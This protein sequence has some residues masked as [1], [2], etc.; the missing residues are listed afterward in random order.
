[1]KLQSSQ[2]SRYR[3]KSL[4]QVWRRIELQGS[5]T[6]FCPNRRFEKFRRR[7]KLQGFQTEYHN[8]RQRRLEGGRNY[9]VLKLV[10]LPI[11]S[12]WRRKSYMVLKPDFFDVPMNFQLGRVIA[13]FSNKHSAWLRWPYGLEGNRIAG[14]SNLLRRRKR[15]PRD[16]KGNRIA[17]CSN[18]A[19]I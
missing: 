12:F 11:H 9:M 14:F 19:A 15:R 1:M 7:K 4:V 5:Q 3:I 16:W 17:G 10:L 6:H 13:G 2:T 18:D 8:A